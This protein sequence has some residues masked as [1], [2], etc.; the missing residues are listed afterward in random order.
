MGLRTWNAR[1][2]RPRM[3]VVHPKHVRNIRQLRPD[4]A[5]TEIIRRTLQQDSSK[6]PKQPPGCPGHETNNDE[7]SGE[8]GSL[9]SGQ[10]D[11]ESGDRHP[12][13]GIEVRYHV[14]IGTPDVEACAIGLGENPGRTEVDDRPDHGNDEDHS[15]L[16]VLKGKEPDDGFHSDEKCYR[17]QGNTVRTS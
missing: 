2:D 6:I 11:D 5:E 10:Q 17:C 1:S 7:R 16:E 15:A 13:E 4:I 12:D 14:G 8:V 3:K 9:P